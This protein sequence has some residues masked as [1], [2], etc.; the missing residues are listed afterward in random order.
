MKKKSLVVAV[1]L[2]MVLSL[3]ACSVPNLPFFNKEDDNG[4]TEEQPT[5]TPGTGEDRVFPI[6]DLTFNTGDTITVNDLVTIDEMYAGDVIQTA[7]LYDGSVVTGSANADE[8][9]SLLNAGSE[10]F[11]VMVEFIDGVVYSGD[12]TIEIVDA[13]P[14]FPDELHNNIAS[15][16]WSTITI[17]EQ[18]DDIMNI[19]SSSYSVSFVQDAIEI[20]TAGSMISDDGRP[21]YS[22]S[23]MDSSKTFNHDPSQT[24][25]Q[26]VPGL[27]LVYQ[28]ASSFAEE[29]D[30][31]V[32][33]LG[34][35][36]DLYKNSVTVSV[37][38]MSAKLYGADGISYP[39]MGYVYTVDFSAY[40]DKS[41][42]ICDVLYIDLPD[43]RLLFTS[44]DANIVEGSDDIVPGDVDMSSITSYDDFVQLV[45]NNESLRNAVVGFASSRTN[46]VDMMNKAPVITNNVVLGD[47]SSL[48]PKDEPGETVVETPPDQ[49]EEIPTESGVVGDMFVP[50]NVRHPYLYTW[51]EDATKYRR[52]VYTIDDETQYISSIIYP[53][54]TQRVSGVN[55]GSD[56]DWRLETGTGSGG[57]TTNPTN[58][59][60][61]T[62]SSQYASYK[63]KPIDDVTF[64]QT[65]STTGRLSVSYGGAKFYIETIRPAQ[66]QNY[67]STS[68][69]PVSNYK[70][71]KYVITEEQSDLVTTDIGLITP[72][73][74]KYTD[75]SGK[76]TT[77]GYMAV[78]NISNDYLC[79]YSDS[80]PMDVNVFVNLLKGMVTK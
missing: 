73:T 22:L 51:A 54:G 56:D 71:N 7:V 24:D 52:W 20:V 49:S 29:G 67:L 64:N 25:F 13:G 43:G 80:L 27:E 12:V 17:A 59:D 68:L 65:E 72:Y 15:K 16:Q 9:Y 2:S 14:E 34:H 70:N 74:V 62:L 23:F 32:A 36:L 35:L 60:N 58:P 47:V 10:V 48:L 6:S 21:L 79:I 53:D 66:V 75:A 39:I 38:D 40:G 55:G 8:P 46:P 30:T 1:V 31:N 50:Y 63:V 28:M 3:T 11:T 33:I 37:Q 41:Y 26:V 77:S 42:T 19:V 76:E 45:M 4:S 69:Y 44:N 57:T 78:Y 5:D 18:S 61:Y